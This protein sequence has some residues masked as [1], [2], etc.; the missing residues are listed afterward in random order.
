MLCCTG[1]AKAYEDDAAY[2]PR[3][4][5]RSIGEA[6][7]PV[8]DGARGRRGAEVGEEGEERCCADG[9]D[10][11]PVRVAPFEDLWGVA[12]ESCGV[13]RIISGVC[14]GGT[15]HLRGSDSTCIRKSCRMTRRW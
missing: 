4:V 11:E 13:L 6:N 8:E 3:C 7:E 15:S 12:G 1:F 14:W 5:P 9:V 10:G 2:D